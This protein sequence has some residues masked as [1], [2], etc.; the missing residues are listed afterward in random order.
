MFLI[1]L[2]NVYKEKYDKLD[3]IAVQKTVV[4]WYNNIMYVEAVSNQ[5]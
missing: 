1:H 4:V 5:E 2:I 3:K